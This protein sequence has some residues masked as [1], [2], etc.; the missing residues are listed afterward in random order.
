MP[1]LALNFSKG[2]VSL[3]VGGRGNS[4]NFG[5]RGVKQTVG[6]RGT[7]ISFSE[8]HSWSKISGQS[9]EVDRAR[10]T[11]RLQHLSE[12]VFRNEKEQEYYQSKLTD[13]I[14]QK[15]VSLLTPYEARIWR[16]LTGRIEAAITDVSCYSKAE[17][18]VIC[19]WLKLTKHLIDSGWAPETIDQPRLELTKEDIEPGKELTLGP[20]ELQQAQL[21]P[22]LPQQAAEPLP[23]RKSTI[24]L[25]LIIAG[26]FIIIFE[27]LAHWL[28]S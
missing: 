12:P 11:G 9:R 14:G 4:V 2:G 20:E 17:L 19:K 26:V 5:K 1:G 3:S 21:P 23:R 24:T 15:A 7:G 18:N 16:Q 28:H 22:P 27:L 6:L 25:L 13:E 8:I 10:S